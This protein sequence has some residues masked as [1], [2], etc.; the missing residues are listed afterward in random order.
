MPQLL[1]NIHGII[2]AFE[3]YAGT[4]GGCAVLTRGQLR[5]LLEQEFADVIAQPHDPAIVD[6]VLRLLDEDNTGTIEF[7][8]FLV[9]VFKVAQACFK[10]LSESLGRPCGSQASGSPHLQSSAELGEGQRS[11]IEVGRG[12]GGQHQVGSTYGQSEQAYQ[13]QSRSGTQTQSQDILSTQ[14][15]SRDRQD[16][17]QGQ[18]GVSQQTQATRHVEQTSSPGGESHQTR[19]R[20]PERQTSEQS[21]KNIASQTQLGATQTVEQDRNHQTGSTGTQTQESFYGQTRGTVT[22]S[23]DRR[24][25]SQ[26]RSGGHI[27]TQEGAHSQTHTQTAEQDRSHPT[28]ITGTQTQG[29]SCGQTRGTETHGQNRSQTSRVVTGGHTQTQAGSY[30]QTVQRDSSQAASHIGQGQT[31]RQFAAL[32]VSAF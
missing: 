2:E 31:Q 14:V 20:R 24:Q 3:R 12:G 22:H 17:A 4:E 23:F 10:T 29:S 21:G 28:G 8:E 1:R 26:V 5:R 6:E 18:E 25:T 15:S 19:G 9:L 16:E 11:G 30:T 27:Q 32:A 7:E 13:G